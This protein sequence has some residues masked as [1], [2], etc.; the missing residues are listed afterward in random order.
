MRAR[1]TRA[2]RMGG[3]A[4]VPGDKSISHRAVMFSA[5]ADG[6][7]E[8]EG[9]SGGADVRSTAACMAQL[10]ATITEAGGVTRI[11]GV[12]AAGLQEPAG[13]LDCGN[14]GTTMRLL[15]GIIAGAGIAATLDG[16]ASLRKR[17]MQRVLDPLRGI[18][19]RCTGV[20]N[21]KGAE[22][23]PLTFERGARLRGET[24]T[25]K[26]ASAQMKSCLLLAGLYA[27]GVTTVR[28][29][30]LSRD[31]TE[32]MLPLY[33][34]K[35]ENTS[36]RGPAVPLHAPTRVTIP[37][38]FSSAAF[39]IAAAAMVPGA[40]VT[41]EGVSANPTRTGFFRTVKRMGADI[42]ITPQGERGGD[43]VAAYRVRG[44]AKLKAIT[45]DSDI[46][47]QID[48]IP[49]FAILATQA[50][51][52]TIIRGAE[53]LRVKESDR[54]A[55][56]ARNLKA[57]GAK[58][59]ELPDG[60]IIEGNQKLRGATIETAHDHRLAM[61]FSVAALCAEGETIIE[62]AQWADISFPGFYN[63]LGQ[64]SDARIVTEP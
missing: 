2:T 21:E 16:D 18:G 28:E 31:H 47:A 61:G 53:E 39:L 33:G 45:L 7:V 24:H 13:V 19:A 54:L 9:L 34:V 26:I 42:T 40:D 44:G 41:I 60:L 6:E 64:L 59:E 52:Q 1:I 29:P 4:R 10:G 15:A 11:R 30:E 17:P 14:S 20:R 35:V 38:D 50:D 25:L 22:V 37:G 27:D 46:P 51:G 56:V 12:G 5:L 58:L 23:A 36:L 43:P 48:E 8:I 32:L 49:M 63:L 55:L 57:M 3:S 62:E